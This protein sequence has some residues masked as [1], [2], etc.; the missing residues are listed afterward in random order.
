VVVFNDTFSNWIPQ[1]ENIPLKISVYNFVDVSYQ[2][3]E[4][5]KANKSMENHLPAF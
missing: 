1:S 5:S 2:N 3:Q 4:R